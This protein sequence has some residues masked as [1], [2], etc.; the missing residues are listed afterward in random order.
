MQP[1]RG[2]A[3]ESPAAAVGCFQFDDL[4]QI[5]LLIQTQT[6][7]SLHSTILGCPERYGARAG[8]FESTP[9]VLIAQADHALCRPQVIEDAVA[10]QNLDER[11]A[12]GADALG[13][14]QTPLRI[15]HQIGLRVGRQMVSDARS[16]AALEQT[17]MNGN[18][19]VIAINANRMCCDLD[20]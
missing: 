5:G 16:V 19:F 14:C 6:Q 20:P 4:D 13:L 1:V 7:N 17:R 15:T 8:G 3:T 11:Q 18:E 12:G 2:G 10:K 9:A